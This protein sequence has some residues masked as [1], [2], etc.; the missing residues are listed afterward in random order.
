MKKFKIL[1]V[2]L[3]S[4]L[5]L[6]GC[7]KDPTFEDVSGAFNN[8]ND[9]TSYTIT[10]VYQIDDNDSIYEEKTLLLGMKDDKK[11]AKLTT[12]AK[13]LNS[14][15]DAGDGRFEI[16]NLTTYFYNNQIGEYVDEVLTWRAGLIE[17]LTNDMNNTTYNLDK[18]YFS[19]YSV[20]E[21]AGVL[22]LKG[23]I[24][25]DKINDFFN[26]TLEGV[27]ELKVTIQVANQDKSPLS[28]AVEYKLNGK[29]CESVIQYGYQVNEINF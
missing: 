23:S 4:V 27:S 13:R 5:V 21:N 15:E 18:A 9:A 17:E 29:L 20:V 22:I 19:E 24:K 25:Q 3:L 2:V 11:I 14:F 10:N 7:S 28:F 16:I 1:L 26:K 6:S 12:E 8:L